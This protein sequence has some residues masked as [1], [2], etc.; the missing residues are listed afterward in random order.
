MVSLVLFNVLGLCISAM[1]ARLGYFVARNLTAFHYY[2][3][4]SRRAAVLSNV[5]HVLANSP[6]PRFRVLT[7][8]QIARLI[9]RSFNEFLFEFFKIPVL[10]RQRIERAFSFEGLQNLD[11]ALSKGNGVIIASA[12]IGN[13]EMGGAALALLGYK[14]HVVAAIQFSSSLSEHVK[15]VKRRLNINVV[16]PEEGY[17]ALFR[18][19]KDNEVVVLL[20]DGDVFAN[21]LKLDFFSE[22]ARISS[23]AAALALKTNAAIV[24]GYVK[25]EGPLRFRMSVG[26]PI[27]PVSTG[28]KAED[29]EKLFRQVLSRVES[30]IEENLDQ[31]CIFRGVWTDEV[32]RGT[33]SEAQRTEEHAYYDSPSGS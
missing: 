29:I 15:D 16:S 12:H 3:F 23:G 32:K 9:F 18:A 25:R 21:G 11:S 33:L 19:L 17:R 2:L 24:S 26:E 8:N 27:L 13:W 4:P 22:P 10:N 14:L 28:N 7:E 30:Y 5:R 31:W 1:P 20:V 6:S